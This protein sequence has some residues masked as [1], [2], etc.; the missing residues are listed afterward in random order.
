ME[1]N[2]AAQIRAGVM[3]RI[4]GEKTPNSFLTWKRVGPRVTQSTV[5]AKEMENSD[6]KF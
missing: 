6:R 5:K 2:K 3:D 1:K 4:S